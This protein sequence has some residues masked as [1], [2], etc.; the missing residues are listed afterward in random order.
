MSDQASYR[1][2]Y[3]KHL[4][5]CLLI[6]CPRPSLRC[7]FL[8]HVGRISANYI[9]QTPLWKTFSKLLTVGGTSKRPEGGKK[10]QP[11]CLAIVL[12]LAMPSARHQ[13][14]QAWVPAETAQFQHQRQWIF[15]WLHLPCTGI[16]SPDF[17]SARNVGSRLPAATV[18]WGTPP[19]AAAQPNGVTP[20]L[21]CCFGPGS[22]TAIL[23]S[24]IA[25]NSADTHL[26]DSL[27][28]CLL[29]SLPFVSFCYFS[30]AF[31][32]CY[33]ICYFLNFWI[34]CVWNT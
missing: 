6:L 21:F 10:G 23:Q 4:N 15:T 17:C 24:L 16:V 34:Q 25:L 32:I 33:L 13:Q 18:V 9:F 29:L 11:L 19:S 30:G 26:W 14:V 8:Y 28:F 3:I 31:I 7:S 2:F 22:G 20:F 1:I 12:V 5:N 27:F